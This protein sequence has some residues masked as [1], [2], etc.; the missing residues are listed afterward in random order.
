[1]I[2]V[3]VISCEVSGI[4]RALAWIIVVTVSHTSRSVD[5]SRQST[6]PRSQPT[7]RHC[8]QCQLSTVNYTSST[9]LECKR[10]LC[11]A[12]A[13]LYDNILSSYSRPIGQF[14]KYVGDGCLI[15]PTQFI[16]NID[17]ALFLTTS[18]QSFYIH[19]LW[20]IILQPVPH[21]TRPMCCSF[22]RAMH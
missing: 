16:T 22:Y 18:N 12:Y 13:F 4:Y 8:L 20:F 10:S 5:L 7:S 1:M 17:K 14:A 9:I 11:K 19:S 6:L 3:D 21:Y 15:Y 2:V